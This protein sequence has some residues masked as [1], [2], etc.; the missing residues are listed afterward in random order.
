MTDTKHPSESENLQN[1]TCATCSCAYL[2]KP[3]AVPTAEQLRVNPGLVTAKP[4]LLCRLNP[5]IMMLAPPTAPGQPPQM[6]LMQAP[7]EPY[8][9]CWHW[10][11][12]GTL[13]G[14]VIPTLAPAKRL[15]GSWDAGGGD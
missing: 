2:V 1:R 7:T 10:K 3:P 11:E 4:Q 5:P 15:Y 8:M 12:P 13:P 9:S 6:K 14:D